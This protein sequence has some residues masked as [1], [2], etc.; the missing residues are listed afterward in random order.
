MRADSSFI[1][2][3]IFYYI[4]DSSNHGSCCF[5]YCIF[6]IKEQC[7]SLKASLTLCPAKTK[8]VIN[9]ANRWI[10][11][12]DHGA[13]H[14]FGL[15]LRHHLLLNIFPFPLNTAEL[16]CDFYNIRRSRT[17]MFPCFAYCFVYL[18]LRQ[19]YRCCGFYFAD[20]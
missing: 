7:S 9:T 13:E 17:N 1:P 20:K 4:S 3:D 8:E 16:I 19:H 2:Y 18:M 14:G 10:L 6:P 11:A 12:S 15:V 5:L